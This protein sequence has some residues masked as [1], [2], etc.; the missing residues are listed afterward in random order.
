VPCAKDLE[1]H[2]DREADPFRKNMLCA[3]VDSACKEPGDLQQL[4]RVDIAASVF[5]TVVKSVRV[6]GEVDGNSGLSG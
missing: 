4:M 5:D 3:A 1:R 2:R 6:G